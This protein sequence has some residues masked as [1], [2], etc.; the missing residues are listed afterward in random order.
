MAGM[1][2]HR[3]HNRI[4]HINSVYTYVNRIQMEGLTI[5]DCTLH[6]KLNTGIHVG[7]IL[8]T[9]YIRIRTR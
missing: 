6:I 2:C 5:T 4:L 1:H 9:V 3:F 7:I 8:Y